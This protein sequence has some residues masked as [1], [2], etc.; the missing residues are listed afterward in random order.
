MVSYKKHVFMSAFII[1][2]V[3][4]TFGILISYALDF[5]RI[6]EIL[7]VIAEHELDTE[8]YFLEK[9]LVDTF[10]GNK[11]EIMYQRITELKEE[12]KEVG[13]DLS[14]YGQKS[15]F[16][17]KD[18]DYLKRKYFILQIKFYQLLE[19]VNKDCDNN[20][21]PILFFYEIDDDRSE[22]QGY[23]LNEISETYPRKVLVFTIDKDYEDEPLVGVLVKK[24]NITKAPTLI[25]NN[26]IKKEGLFYTGEVNATILKIIRKTDPY[27]ENY[28]FNF[29]IDAARINK[30]R[31]I[32]GYKK[33]IRSNIS[34]IAKADALV[35][36][37]RILDNDTMLCSSLIYYDK[38]TPINME[39]QALIY[40][41]FASIGCGRNRRAFLLKAS[42]I[43]KSLGNDFR[44]GL[45]KDLAKKNEIN[46]VFDTDHNLTPQNTPKNFSSITIGNVSAKLSIGDILVS[47]VDRVSRDWI[48][49]QLNQSVFGDEIL[50][51]FSERLSYEESELHPEIGWHEGARIKEMKEIDIKNKIAAGT[52]VA[53][54]KKKWYAPNENGVFMFEVPIDK[55]LYP[56][57]RFLR[58]DIAVIMDT[59]GINMLVE[60]SIRYNATLVIGCCD[61]PGKIKAAKYLAEQG[62]TVFCPTDKYLPLLLNSSLPILGSAP[63]KRNGNL[64]II[65][66]QPITIYPNET[67]I[68]ENVSDYENVQSYYDTPTRYFKN[69][70]NIVNIENIH[71]YSLENMNQ[72]DKLI[73]F[74]EKNNASV[75]ALRV[76]SLDDYT[77][78]SSW[79]KKD[80]DNKAVLFHSISY[81]YGY[82]IFKEFP[83]QTAF[84]DINP[85]I[86]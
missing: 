58:E 28:N 83:D 6:D 74:A 49:Y 35:V 33:M 25:I 19:Q 78:I 77:A 24:F 59:H 38:Y 80:I 56:T 4:F 68:V 29:T 70:E 53:K 37:G 3:I 52:I 5:A 85:V 7:S 43:W 63:I 76:F 8:S 26:K 31:L 61:H 12:I 13:G 20:Y 1:T 71:Y 22:R 23:I 67:I 44:A 39:E 9:E 16:K 48:S 14:S 46:L 41:T 17:K 64:I 62:M 32:E 55:L 57:T 69:L 27:A 40:E 81:P 10:G 79:L 86:K 18:Y 66:K 30:T 42:S 21:I 84:D 82:M 15:F 75:I 11:C 36:L 34:D 50:S 73:S 51:V 65:G 2:V 54:H 47:Q 45:D 72:A 60:Q